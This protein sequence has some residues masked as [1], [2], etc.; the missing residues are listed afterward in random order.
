M[1]RRV[2]AWLR[3]GFTLLEV[4]ATVAILSILAAAAVPSLAAYMTRRN[5]ETTAKIF[6][7]LQVGVDSM[8]VTP[9]LT[10][11]PFRLSH[12]GR[13]VLGSGNVNGQD[14]TSCSGIGA[15][16]PMA[17]YTST[18]AVNQNGALPFFHRT[19]PTTGFPTPIG[20]VIDTLYRTSAPGT[21][22]FLPLIIRNVSFEDANELNEVIDGVNDTNQGNRSNT[23]G[24]LIWGVP[25]NE[26]VDVKYN[27]TAASTS[28]L[29]C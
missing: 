7:E 21:A 11:Y 5:I 9:N 19:I 23:T 14:T 3:A 15:A 26:M 22:G 13:P 18:Q 10:A 4:V 25:V 27:I 28:K 6:A 8:R 24:K 2:T 1:L 29:P 12:L 17:L 16:T 20:T